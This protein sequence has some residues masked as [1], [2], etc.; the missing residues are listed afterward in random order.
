MEGHTNLN[1]GLNR[2]FWRW[3]EPADGKRILQL[4]T[5]QLLAKK[6]PVQKAI[7]RP[8][9]KELALNTDGE[10]DQQ[11]NHSGSNVLQSLCQ[12]DSEEDE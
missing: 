3:T 10:S 4:P 2:F 7:G 5:I 8:E 1:Y 12:Y 9:E 6:K 11:G